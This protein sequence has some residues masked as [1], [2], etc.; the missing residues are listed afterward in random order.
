MSEFILLSGIY[1]ALMFFRF[2]QFGT[3]TFSP[4]FEMGLTTD[5]LQ[6]CMYAVVAYYVNDPG[7]MAIQYTLLVVPAIMVAYLLTR[8]IPQQSLLVGLITG[9]ICATLI[10]ASLEPPLLAALAGITGIPLGGLISSSRF[11]RNSS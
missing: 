10:W 9:V 6:Q 8:K 11:A 1:M 4:C 3:E 5:E 7:W 2:N